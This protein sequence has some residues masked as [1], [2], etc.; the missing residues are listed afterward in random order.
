MK[1]SFWCIFI[2]SDVAL[3]YLQ[4]KNARLAMVAFLGFCSEAAVTG[5]GPIEGLKAHIA[6]PSNVN[7]KC[8]RHEIK[9]LSNESKK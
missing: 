1:C 3:V 5:M 8:P 6:D 9:R 7:S 2:E 4:V